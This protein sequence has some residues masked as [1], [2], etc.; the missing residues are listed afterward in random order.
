MLNG[1][2]SPQVWWFWDQERHGWWRWG[3]P[4]GHG[5]AGPL[6]RV[7]DE[8]FG[9]FWVWY[10]QWDEVAQG[11]IPPQE[12]WV[13]WDT[14]DE[15]DEWDTGDESDEGGRWDDY[16]ERYRLL[17]EDPDGEDPPGVPDSGLLVPLAVTWVFFGVMYSAI[18]LASNLAFWV[19]QP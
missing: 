18:R 15:W 5:W 10:G 2:G 11:W 16:Y 1:T 3:E 13:E 4:F 8:R 6:H 7:A 17:P 19:V 14:E 12:E 9:G